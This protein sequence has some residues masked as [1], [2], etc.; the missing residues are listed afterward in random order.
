M[1]QSKL[2]I[3]FWL[4][5]LKHKQYVMNGLPKGYEISNEIRNIERPYALPPLKIHYVEKYVSFHLTDLRSNRIILSK[6][7]HE[8]LNF[9]KLSNIAGLV[10]VLSLF[11]NKSL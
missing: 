9:N 6:L 1:I 10:K 4:G 7:K 5:L 8:G 2:D 3:Y 11:L